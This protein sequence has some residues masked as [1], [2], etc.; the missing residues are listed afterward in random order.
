MQRL[1]EVYQGTR[2]GIA[3][4]YGDAVARVALGF[5]GELMDRY[6]AEAGQ[7]RMMQAMMG[8]AFNGRR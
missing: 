6:N 7:S 2:V 3:P 5:V 4:P 8:A 1:V